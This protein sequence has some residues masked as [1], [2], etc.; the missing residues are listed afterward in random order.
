MR[1]FKEPSNQI[2]LFDS[3]EKIKR[4]NV[5]LE[6]LKKIRVKLKDSEKH[7]PIDYTLVSLRNFFYFK[8]C[9]RVLAK[10]PELK[11]IP[12]KDLFDNF[13]LM[14]LIS[15]GGMTLI[16][17]VKKNPNLVW[18]YMQEIRLNKEQLEFYIISPY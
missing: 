1:S 13:I 4:D 9:D 2:G 10:H 8:L 6:R 12:F 5:R 11:K 3:P 17:C 15:L 16:D 7:D 14:P 18:A